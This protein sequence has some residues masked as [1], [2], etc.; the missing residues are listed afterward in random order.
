MSDSLYRSR[1][2]VLVGVLTFWSICLIEGL[3]TANIIHE[4]VDDFLDPMLS[5][6]SLW[7]NDWALFAPNIDHYNSKLECVITWD[8][9][10]QTVWSHPDWTTAS[11]GEKF[12][13]FRRIEFY[14]SLIVDTG[15][16]ARP[17]FSNV[18]AQELAKESGKT[19]RLAELMFHGDTILPP[20][21]IWRKAFSSPQ[22][23]PPL[24][25]Y[26]WYPNAIS[27][28]EIQLFGN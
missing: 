7:Q 21:E 9:G 1:P 19:P 18:M 28:S 25:L 4:Q 15:R 10:T 5:R 12:R 22:F 24:K 26:T 8:D 27:E 20:Q 14:E 13:Q 17:A 6:T 2:L 23:D 16:Q 11:W 3:P